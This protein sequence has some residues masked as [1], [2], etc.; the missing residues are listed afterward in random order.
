MR[1]HGNEIIKRRETIDERKEY[2]EYRP[3]IEEDF[4]HI[5][6]YC[7]KSES[8]T[9]NTFEIDH[10]VPIKYAPHRETDYKNLVYSCFVCNRKK[11]SKWPSADPSIQFVDGEGFVDPAS[12]EYDKH[13]E[14]DVEGNIVGKTNV[15]RYMV[16]KGFKFEQRPM[17]EIWKAM[18][19]IEKKKELQKKMQTI[20]AE[21]LQEYV[22]FDQALEEMQKY[23]FG[24]RE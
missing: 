1:V 16:S 5:C 8:V 7:G 17:K 3:E 13:L 2:G 9:K 12:E 14:R 11:S 21:E 4:H 23:L 24:V 10:F 18:Q 20:S 22:I 15:G 6:G 19:L